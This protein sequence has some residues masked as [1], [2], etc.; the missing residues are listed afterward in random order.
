MEELYFNKQFSRTTVWYHG[1]TSTQVN[2]L[3]DGINVYYSKRNC[4]FGIGFYVTSK[5]SQAVKWAKRKT[6]FELPFNPDVKPIVLSY[7]FQDFS[8]VNMKIFEIDREYFQFVYKNRVELNVKSGK[9][10]HD[11]S[12]VFG[13]VLDGNVTCLETTLDGYFNGVNTLEETVDILLGKYQDD[14]Q[15]CICDQVIADKLILVKEE[16]V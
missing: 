10:I 16:T 3:K 9:N 1:T 15:L 8:N 11:F 14:T 13:P 12:A 7:E 2:S 5:L 6:N 4:D